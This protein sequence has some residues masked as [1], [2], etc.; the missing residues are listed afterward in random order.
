MLT[1]ETQLSILKGGAVYSSLESI[2]LSLGSGFGWVSPSVSLE[3]QSTNARRDSRE[4]PG[5][6][7]M[8]VEESCRTASNARQL[9][10]ERPNERLN[11][12][13]IRSRVQNERSFS[14]SSSSTF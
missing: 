8:G 2:A 7:R 4:M 12:S 5:A 14:R 11:R 3:A 13:F 6:V 1:L 10:N 9:I